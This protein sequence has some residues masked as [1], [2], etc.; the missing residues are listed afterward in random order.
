MEFLVVL[1]G[2]AGL[3][4]YYKRLATQA[5]PPPSTPPPPPTQ[6]EAILQSAKVQMTDWNTVPFFGRLKQRSGFVHLPLN[7][8]TSVILPSMV[9][10]YRGNGR[11]DSN[12]NY[13]FVGENMRQY[14]HPE[15]AWAGTIRPGQE[16]V[17]AINSAGLS[18]EGIGMTQDG[19]I[20]LI[21]T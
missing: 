17:L 11:V 4:L 10:G 5:E 12:G 14:K 2:V 6:P 9:C 16:V 13:L 15:V 20:R 1:A 21:A 8:E 18:Y 19:E 3:W 7:K